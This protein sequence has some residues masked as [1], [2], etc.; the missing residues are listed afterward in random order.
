MPFIEGQW[1]GE[2]G[3]KKVLAYPTIIVYKLRG[4][5]PNPSFRIL[6][7]RGPFAIE[8]DIVFL[9]S[10]GFNNH[11]LMVCPS[12]SPS[13]FFHSWR[14]GVGIGRVNM[15]PNIVMIKGNFVF[16]N[17]TRSKRWFV[18]NPM[19]VPCLTLSL[20]FFRIL[21]NSCIIDLLIRS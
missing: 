11:N 17:H 10:R 5:F 12:N 3:I 14:Y 9:A 21:C 16:E 15:S 7:K 2:G 8:G 20:S 18:K 6:D 1:G 13:S 4:I 19:H